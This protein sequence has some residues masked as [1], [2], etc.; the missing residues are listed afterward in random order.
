MSQFSWGLLLLIAAVFG[1]L[2]YRNQRVPGRVGVK[3]GR[4][5]PVRGLHNAVSSQTVDD[6]LLVEPWPFAGDREATRAA[7]RAAV[8]AHGG[9]EILSDNP[10]Y[11]HVVFTTDKMHFHDDVEFLL[12]GTSLQTGKDFIPDPEDWRVH[13]RS[14]SRSGVS[15]RGV[16]RQRI[17]KL[18][19]LYQAQM[20]IAAG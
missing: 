7:L 8:E 11:M 16:N 14:Q 13:I 19:D 18:A 4:L 17:E 2:L 3:D 5:S 1:F 15:D 6:R 12:D 9:G 20:T 10:G